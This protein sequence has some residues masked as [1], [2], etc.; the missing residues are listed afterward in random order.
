MKKNAPELWAN[1]RRRCEVRIQKNSG[2]ER[3]VR[4]THQKK[5]RNSKDSSLFSFSFSFFLFPRCL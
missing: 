3:K 5:G 1:L 2:D 4:S